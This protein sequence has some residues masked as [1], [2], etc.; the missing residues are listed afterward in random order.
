MTTR[1]DD[2]G[3]APGVWVSALLA[4]VTALLVLFGIVLA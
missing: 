3:L 2:T 1:E 4:A